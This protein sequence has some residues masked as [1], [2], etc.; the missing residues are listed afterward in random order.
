MK[1]P[2]SRRAEMGFWDREHPFGVFD[3]SMMRHDGKSLEVREQASDSPCR[4]YLSTSKPPVLALLG[5]FC[6]SG[7][8]WIGKCNLVFAGHNLLVMATIR[9][10]RF[11]VSS[12]PHAHPSQRRGKCASTPE[13]NITAVASMGNQRVSGGLLTAAVALL[14]IPFV[15]NP[16]LLIAGNF[17]VGNP[18][19]PGASLIGLDSLSI[20]SVRPPSPPRPV[21]S[22]P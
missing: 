22:P 6:G 11:F 17:Y 3:R 15:V 13:P 21:P 9:R 18:E 1:H 8:T 14:A 4:F 20:V 16:L 2:L 19:R 7:A 12:K 5:C 10:R